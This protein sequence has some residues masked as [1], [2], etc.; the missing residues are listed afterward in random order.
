LI[1]AL[2]TM[3]ILRSIKFNN[4]TLRN[5]FRQPT[6]ILTN[7]KTS[8]FATTSAF[9]SDRREVQ[10]IKMS[11]ATAFPQDQDQY[12]DKDEAQ[13][14]SQ[15]P[16]P[17]DSQSNKLPL[18]LPEPPSADAPIKLDISTGEGVSLD[19][20]GPMVVNKDGTISRIANWDKMA[21]IEKENTRRIVGRRNQVR[22]EALRKE[23]EGRTPE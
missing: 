13:T 18:G 7:Q 8:T 22:L 23:E 12:R 3:Q 14:Q 2:I 19:A 20:L 21:P 16:Q 1:I 11:S 4:N 15:D 17:Q 9:W 5:S 10:N 6:S